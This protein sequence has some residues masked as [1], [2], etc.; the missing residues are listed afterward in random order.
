MKAGC[1]H[2]SFDTY[3]GYV[4]TSDLAIVSAAYKVTV[5]S[6]PLYKNA[7]GTSEHGPLQHGTRMRY[8]GS[9]NAYYNIVIPLEK[10]WER[11]NV[12][13]KSAHIASA[14]YDRRYQ[15]VLMSVPL[16]T[17]NSFIGKVMNWN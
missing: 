2:V 9:A 7:S 4:S 13:C 5:G 6:T 3:S 14:G 10:D 11:T 17:R 16:R 8:I 1:A 15:H 12:Y